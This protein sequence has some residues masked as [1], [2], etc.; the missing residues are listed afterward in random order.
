MKNVIIY[1]LLALLSTFML[2]L[3]QE[4]VVPLKPLKSGQNVVSANG[5]VKSDTLWSHGKRVINTTR[6]L[7]A[8]QPAQQQ[9]MSGRLE[10]FP[11]FQSQYIEARNVTVWLPEGYVEGEPC[12]V[13]YM[14]DGQMLFDAT[15][16]W[17]KQEWQVDEVMGRLITQG[18]IRRCIVVGIDNS[19]NRLND[20]FPTKCYKYVPQDQRATVDV[21]LY[22]G[23]DYL[24]FLVEEVKPFIDALYRP[25][26]TR[27]HTFVM[28]SSMGG[29]ISLYALCEYPRVF[30]GAVCLSTHLSMRFF[31]PKFNSEAWATVQFSVT[32][33]LSGLF[34][35]PLRSAYCAAKHALFGFY[36]SLE[37]EYDNINVTFLIPGRINTQISKSALM[38]DGTAHAKM[39]AGQA[40]GLDVD[41]CGAI[42]V[43]AIKRQKHRK[44]IG[45]TELLM[46]Y[47]HKYCLPLYY[48][49]SRK[50]SAT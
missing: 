33:S 24:R 9:V 21:S 50:I 3:A 19:P 5:Y 44:L 47:I 16:T 37:L 12:D 31:D 35:F 42:A 2:M 4:E 34:G 7:P 10:L 36:E 43:R 29:L 18:K 17:N 6:V 1:L 49:L 20:Y 46:A 32:T 15:T 11:Q 14:H 25:L 39:D 48:K 40:N 38:G 41:K 28:G 30:G 27:E 8:P 45:R 23:D 13:L 26:T 22:K